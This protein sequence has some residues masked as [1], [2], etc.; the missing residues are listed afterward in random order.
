MYQLDG[1]ANE[2]LSHKKEMTFTFY[3]IMKASIGLYANRMKTGSQI[4]QED[5]FGRGKL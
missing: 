5:Q 3:D 4:K 1:L 2:D